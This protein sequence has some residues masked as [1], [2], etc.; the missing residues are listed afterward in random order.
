MEKKTASAILL[1]LLLTSMLTL[2]FNIQQVN[3]GTI[4]VPDDYPT[5]QEAIN[6]ANE[7]D[8]IFVRNGIYYEHIVVSKTVSL[9]GENKS[10]TIID[11]SGTGTVVAL[12]SNN[13]NISGLTLRNSGRSGSDIEYG[14]WLS[15]SWNRVN[16][17]IFLNNWYGVGIASHTIPSN[18]LVG[19]TIEYNEMLDN[20]GGIHIQFSHDNIISHNKLSN[21][22]VG[23]N[24]EWSRRNTFV[25]NLISKNTHIGFNLY[26]GGEGWVSEIGGCVLRDNNMTDNSYNLRVEGDYLPSYIHDIDESNT[27]NG[28]PI[29]YWVNKQYGQIPSDAGYV[30][31]VNSTNVVV[32]DLNLKNNGEG[33]LFA[34]MS[35]SIIEN[36]SISNNMYGIYLAYSD[37]IVILNSNILSTQERGICII[38]GH[39]NTLYRNVISGAWICLDISGSANVIKE[40]TLSSGLYAISLTYAS[41]NFIYHNNFLNNKYQVHSNY[42]SKNNWDN[43]Y[44]SGG[45][46]WSVYAGIDAKSGIYQNETGSDG[47]GDMPY[48]VIDVNNIDHYPLMSPYVP[49]PTYSLIITTTVGGTTDAAPG[50]YSYTANSTVQVTAIPAANYLFE[51]WEL[52]GVNV[53]SANPYSVTMDKGHTLKAVFSPIPPP[54]SASI[55]PLSA[56][57]LAGQSVTFTSTVSGGYTPYSYQWYLNGNP[58][59][60]ATSASWTFTPTTSGI[61]YIYLKVTDAEANTAQSDTARIT[62]P[63]P[64]PVGGY[65]IPIQVQTR[66]QPII[67][68]FAL[69]ATLTLIFTISK[70]K[71]KRRH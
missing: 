20:I 40:N 31:I 8:T 11:G 37:N 61:Y 22:Q 15:S 46:Y 51:Y 63:P 39:K 5:I 9:I 4:T 69:I 64:P 3:A 67:P 30:G 65:S 70:Q 32:K 14:I 18:F 59:S 58:V 10:T 66:T 19:N 28:K 38:E 54:L 33:I 34:H 13:V 36:V 53:G 35:D 47:I 7:G 21:N 56:S 41:N 42:V 12:T 16:G 6:N 57:I 27:V 71:T 45:N 68:Y 62:F 23:I 55:S 25:G 17:N 49:T 2:A 50:T 1:T 44:P 26:Y 29:Y 48:V 24:C 52:D 43:G 60:G